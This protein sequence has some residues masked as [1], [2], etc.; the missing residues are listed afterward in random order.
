MHGEQSSGS[1]QSGLLEMPGS[2]GHRIPL[3][4]LLLRLDALR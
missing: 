1:G 2:S 4:H 3:Q